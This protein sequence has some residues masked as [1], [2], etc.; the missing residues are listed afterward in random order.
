MTKTHPLHI[1][2]KQVRYGDSIS[3]LEHK[4]STASMVASCEFSIDKY[5]E[6]LG[7]KSHI[8]GA[9]KEA[10]DAYFINRPE[11]YEMFK[12]AHEDEIMQSDLK[13]I[14]TYKAYKDSL[15]PLLHKGHAK[16]CVSHAYA[17]EGI[18]YE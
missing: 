2:G 4:Y 11:Q 18:E 16:L 5:M 15:T 9:I 17:L 14:D 12:I 8:S 13:K 3:K 10:L 1:H 6:R 7:K